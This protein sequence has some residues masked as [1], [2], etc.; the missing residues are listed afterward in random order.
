[1]LLGVAARMR[2]ARLLLITD[3]RPDLAG[4]VQ[5]TVAA[6]VDIV[7]F[8]DPRAEPSALAAGYA[9][10]RAELGDRRALLGLYDALELAQPLQ[11]DL[12]QLSE[13]SPDAALARASV[14]PWA[15]VGRSC[16][17]RRQVDAALA[18]PEVDFLT[19][20]PVAGGLFGA[21]GLDLVAY[22]AAAAPVSDPSTKP[23]FAVGGVT[24]ENLDEVI[25]AGARRV[26]VSRA[27][28]DAER[29]AD[30]AAALKARLI[31]AGREDG[32][33]ATFGAF[34]S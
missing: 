24:L 34:G 5:A 6:G 3:L 10:A 18:D 31:Q 4:F 30:A 20:G 22:A 9:T 12:L 21:G 8:R 2:L 27:I 23:W 11:C 25:A 19:V 32:G 29:P 14:H 26:A 17:S 7:Q 15:Q 13:R 28:T 33:L 1:V 16:H